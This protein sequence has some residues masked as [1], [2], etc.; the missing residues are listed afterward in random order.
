MNLL[1]LDSIAGDVYGGLESWIGM[2]SAG[3][4]EKGHRVTAVG[5]PGSEYLRR[6]A[7]Q[8]PKI[9]T[10]GLPI[11]GDFNPATIAAIKRI[12]DERSIDAVI[13]NFNK[14][15]RLGGLA[16]RWR[17]RTR[18]IWRLGNNLTSPK[19]VHRFLTPRLVDGAITPSHELKRQVVASGYIKPEMVRVIHT[20]VRAPR[21][22]LAGPE[23]RS[24]LREKYSLPADSRIAVTS[25]RFVSQKG[26]RYLVEAAGAIVRRHP[27]VRFLWLGDGPLEDELRAQIEGA[28]LSDRF[29]FAG[30][31]DDFELE[32]AGSDMMVHPATIEPFGI[33]LLEAMRVGLPIVASRVG[34]IPEV[35]ADNETGDL[36]PPKDT[37]ALGKAVTRLLD[38]PARM[39]KLGVAAEHRWR[40]EFDYDVMLLRLET[41]LESVI[42]GAGEGS[43]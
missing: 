1:F 14:D 3:M 22:W 36:I 24:A 20:G 11:S 34:G 7:L 9:E 12:F 33:V 41:Y 15:L 28:G 32:M 10:I 21:T 25:G 35:V 4:I 39:I 13:C 40:S 37:A 42:G 23:A 29:V 8:S 31:L 38:E 17:G 5:R 6:T 43:C 30:L 19:A 18:V 26:H 2:V 27:E 16:A